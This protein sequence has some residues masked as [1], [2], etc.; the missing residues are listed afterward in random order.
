MPFQVITGGKRPVT[1]VAG[2]DRMLGEV[3]L[4]ERTCIGENN[5]ATFALNGSVRLDRRKRGRHQKAV[6]IIG[7]G[8][9]T[10][11][12]RERRGIQSPIERVFFHRLIGRI[13]KT[14]TMFRTLRN[15]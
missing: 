14:G 4:L 3:V 10:H 1:D 2:E 12:G 13:M 15:R 11:F 7:R 6:R 8:R 5:L 9:Q